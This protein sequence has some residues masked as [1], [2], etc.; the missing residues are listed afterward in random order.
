MAIDLNDKS[1]PI[2]GSA[3]LVPKDEIAAVMEVLQWTLRHLSAVDAGNA[4]ANLAEPR[5]RPL[6]LAVLEAC[7]QL[8]AWTN[9]EAAEALQA[10][11]AATNGQPG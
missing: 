11:R 1:I 6:T 7:K 3:V 8:E 4:A 5:P 9:P 2:I 10:E